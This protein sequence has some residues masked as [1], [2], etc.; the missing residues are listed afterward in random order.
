VKQHRTSL[1]G[2]G[3]VALVLA[4]F[5]ITALNRAPRAH[6]DTVVKDP[7]I[8]IAA[9]PDGQGYWVAAADGGVFAFGTALFHGSMGG[10]HLNAPVVAM[11]ATATGKGYWLAAADGGIFAFGDAQ[12]HGSMGGQHLNAPVVGIA[13]TPSGNGYWLTAAD[14]GIFAFGD[15]QFHGSMGGQHLNA[16]VVGIAGTPSGNGYW[17]TAKDGGV[18]NFGDAGFHGSMGG[19]PLAGSIVGTAATGT[20]YWELGSDGGIFAFGSARYYGR[21]VYATPTSPPAGLPSGDPRALA[22]Q[23]INDPRINKSGRLVLSDLQA[24]AAGR[25]ASAGKMLSATILRMIVV[26]ASQNHTMYITALESGHTGHA[27]NSYHYSG[28]AVDF[29]L[30]DGKTLTG[31]DPKSLIIISTLAALMPSGS[32]F[33]QSG[34]YAKNQPHVTL[35]ADVTEFPDTCNHLHV[36]V[37][38]NSA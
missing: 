30:L 11:A 4:A 24:A 35:P 37:A 33:G 29:G 25:P 17:L 32:G 21:V 2:A 6:A 28:D 9:S 20:G 22:Q 3:L 15:A 7:P 19:Q 23:I 1:L 13:G 18:F 26:L 12:F 14:G 8:A 38:R 5:A 16:P 34:C 27:P 36:Q 31:R 10:Q